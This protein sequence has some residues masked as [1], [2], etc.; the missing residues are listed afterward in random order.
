MH[1]LLKIAAWV[2]VIYLGYC[3]LLFVLQ[4]SVLFPRNQIPFSPDLADT[5][6]GLEKLWIDTE[7]GKI[8]AWFLPPVN[9]RDELP[10][11]AVIFGHG[12]A[13]LIDHWPEAF[14][15][16]S[17]MGIGLLLVE[18]PG[19]G[20]SSGTPSEQNIRHAFVA[21]YD[22]L[23][24]RKGIDPSR[25]VLFGRSLGGGA[26]CTL[27]LERPSAALILMSTFTSVQSMAAKFGVPAFLVRDRFNN[28]EA[29]KR[30]AGPI[31]IIHGKDDNL[32]P[33]THGVKLHSAAKNSS[34]I[35]YSA[36]HNDCPPD[37]NRF[38]K[39]LE[40]FL[41]DNRIL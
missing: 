41:N 2:F 30:Y 9:S 20:R 22:A 3:G 40:L 21:A 29:I 14:K 38:W 28:L 23:V 17:R 24:S 39:D 6:P 18:Y 33:Y 4:R 7:Y 26:V 32:I 15:N 36:G 16:F 13:E 34:L 31:L 5:L 19:Y 37:W 35:T 1:S 12:N 25:I 10:A 8:E 11:P 27:A